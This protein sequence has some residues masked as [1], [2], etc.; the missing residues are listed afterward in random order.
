MRE[1]NYV[2][3]H[4]IKLLKSL[5]I[6]VGVVVFIMALIRLDAKNYAQFTAD[7]LFSFILLFSYIKLKTDKRHYAV[8]ARTVLFFAIAMAFYIVI[9]MHDQPMRFIWFSSVVYLMFYLLDKKE[10][11]RWAFFI[12]ML[13]AVVFIYDKNMLNLDTKD[14]F[15]WLF[16]MYI[17]LMIVNWYE[18]IKEEFTQKLLK[19]QDSL[20]S[21]VKTKTLELQKLNAS[22][23]RRIEEKI[24]KNRYHEQT[25]LQQSRLAQMG[26]MISMIAHQWRQPLT[27]ISATSSLIE[28]KAKLNQLD[29]DV[30]Q[31]KAKDI[32]SYA[33]HL[34]HTIDDFRDFFKPNKEKKESTY[35][36]VVKSVLGIIESSISNKNIQVLQELNCHNTFTTYPNELRQVVLNLIKNAEDILLEKKVKNPYIK[37]KAYQKN[38]KHILEISD[39]GGGIPNDIIEKIFDPYF[40]TKSEK[41]GTGLGLY[42]SKT[43]IEEHCGGTLSV[44]ND[45]DGAIFKIVLQSLSSNSKMEDDK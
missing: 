35:N 27:A 3:E 16:N 31:K 28:L 44:S 19:I 5:I 25:I 23:E 18:E 10:G 43:I 12:G 20:A 22:L 4:K 30:V 33:Q 21:E 9:N 1:K 41:N 37:I 39:N 17:I 15:I 42:M 13:L 26:E 8:V 24:E 2:L 32:S 45:N 7:I 29:T 6:L 11:Q 34:S 14:F 38:E 36:E 40:S